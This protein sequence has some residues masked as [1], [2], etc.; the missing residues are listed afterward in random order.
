MTT[1][2]KHKG[3]AAGECSPVN[4]GVVCMPRAALVALLLS[5]EFYRYF[6]TGPQ[7]RRIL[8]DVV[9]S[10]EM[11]KFSVPEI[12]RKEIPRAE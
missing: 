8:Y 10:H 4:D 1:L 9:D 11:P 2:S 3:G 6:G 7:V 5:P 12:V